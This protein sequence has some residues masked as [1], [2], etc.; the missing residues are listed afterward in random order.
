MFFNQFWCVYLNIDILC[1]LCVAKINAILI[2]W[3][4]LMGDKRIIRQNSDSNWSGNTQKLTVASFESETFLQVNTNT[5]RIFSFSSFC[6]I[7]PSLAVFL[8]KKTK[9]Q[10]C[11][12]S[13]IIEISITLFHSKFFILFLIHGKWIM[14]TVILL[15]SEYKNINM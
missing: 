6:S 7:R 4:R 8:P 9:N 3:L 1:K 15:Y 5:S 11:S 13:V 2:E 12:T 10:L 14:I